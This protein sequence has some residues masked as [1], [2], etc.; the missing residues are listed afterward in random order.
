MA[1]AADSPLHRPLPL[2]RRVG[3]A[4][5]LSLLCP[6]WGHLYVGAV[7]RGLLFAV[8][9]VAVVIPGIVWMWVAWARGPL[10]AL[11]VLALCVVAALVLP[12]DAARLAF[13]RPWPRT[14]VVR[15]VALHGLF[16]PLAICV[17]HTELS[18]IRAHR[19]QIFQTPTVSMAPTLLAGD[20][21]LVDARPS[22]RENLAPGDIVVFDHPRDPG[23]TYA[24]RV[25]ALAESQVAL[26][27]D[28]LLV[29]GVA[30]TLPAGDYWQRL[31]TE[32]LGSTE[33]RVM[34]GSPGE[35]VPFPPVEVPEGHVF[36]L[37]DSRVLSRDSREF[38][39]LSLDQVRGRV[40]RVVWSFDA[41]QSRVRW[42]R[43]G[44]GFAEMW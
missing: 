18:W 27:A 6:G 20:F 19:V 5:A 37:G 35:L 12:L 9:N 16:V 44:L 34:L 43:L 1:L 30:R 25:V 7:K 28:G 39:P 24:K 42:S 33:Y 11:G 38:G 41:E 40:V 8:L 3:L 26:A 2:S 22:T 14:R 36:V 31:R 32:R 4:M 10:E 17:L 23:V 29:D 21:F 13:V 15:V